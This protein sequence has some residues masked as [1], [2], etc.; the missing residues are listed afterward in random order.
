MKAQRN[1]WYLTTCLVLSSLTILPRV[2]THTSTRPFQLGLPDSRPPSFTAH[3]LKS[4]IATPAGNLRIEAMKAKPGHGQVGFFRL[5]PSTF[6]DLTE[7][8]VQCTNSEN[9]VLF[10]ITAQKGRYADDSLE[11]RHSIVIKTPHQPPR[12]P[13]KVT[14]DLTQGLFQSR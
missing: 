1:T 6:V 7:V 2:V 4:L 13:D 8:R 5:G 10:N 12:R 3:G 9:R 11:L 14:I